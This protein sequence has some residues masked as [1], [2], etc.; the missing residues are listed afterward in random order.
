MAAK[1]LKQTVKLGKRFRVFLD[2][3]LLIP[4]NQGIGGAL[5]FFAI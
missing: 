4:H 3:N 5:R 1:K 2:E